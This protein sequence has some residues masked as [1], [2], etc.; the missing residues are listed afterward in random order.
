MTETMD[1]ERDERPVAPAF[2]FA[3]ALTGISAIR[4]Y[5]SIRR[6]RKLGEDAILAYFYDVLFEALQDAA[7][8]DEEA[9]DAAA[10]LTQVP[11][12][13]KEDEHGS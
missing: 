5:V 13:L 2:T 9:F 8:E 1:R 11:N 12:W 4:D 6:S 3:E 10:A 7:Q